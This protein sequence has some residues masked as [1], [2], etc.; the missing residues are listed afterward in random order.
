MKS[1]DKK[2]LQSKTVDELKESL[3]KNQ[4]ELS[5]MRLEHA[6]GK[7]KNF[8]SLSTK[9]REIAMIETIMREKE[10]HHENV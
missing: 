2:Q 9:R 5:G 10:L 6:Q 8:S 4:E 1:K 3:K 7:L